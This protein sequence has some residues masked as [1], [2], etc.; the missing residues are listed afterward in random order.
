VTSNEVAG[1]AL[2]RISH[3]RGSYLWDTSGK[4]YI[5]GS[6]GPAVYALGHGNREVN[7]AIARQLDQIAHGYRYLF[8]ADALDD[9]TD[10]LGDLAGGTLRRMVFV[11][12]GSEAMESALKIALQYHYARGEPRR[13][14]FIARERSYHGNTLTTTALSGFAQRREAFEQALPAM[15][16]VSAANAYRPPEG[17]NPADLVPALAAELDQ[18]FQRLGPE[19]VAGFVFEPVVGAAGGV[20]PAPPGYAEAVQRICR[21]HGALVIADEVMCGAGRCG[22]WRAL[23]HDGIVPDIMAVAKSL[24]AGYL[25]LGAAIYTDEIGQVLDRHAG[26]P[27]TGHTYTGHTTCLA[28]GLAVQQIIR[29]ERL[30]QRVGANGTLWQAALAER[31]A[32]F[33][34]VGD[35]RGRGYFIGI[36]L[37]CNHQTK[38][39]FPAEFGLHA[40]IRRTALERGLICYP[41]GGHLA[42]GSGDTVILAP[43]FNATDAEL[44]EIA[45]K[46]EAAIEAALL[47]IR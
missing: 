29:R 10:L 21:R 14:R 34:A 19:T 1:S 8:T 26:G 5:D 28:A 38:A 20:V 25:P 37:V 23:E 39:P 4:Q 18:E 12:G 13:V 2:P 41:S 15:G 36:E 27:L 43:P 11:T 22:T 40:R 9:L 44:D 47:E 24:S 16:R 7:D 33:D 30:I 6:G 17:L 46:L 32:R 3:G 42:D 31:L 35:V 45:V